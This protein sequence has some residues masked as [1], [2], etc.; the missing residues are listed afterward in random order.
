MAID[1]LSYRSGVRPQSHSRDVARPRQRRAGVSDDHEA[2][3]RLVAEKII[4]EGHG[5]RGATLH[6]AYSNR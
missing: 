3:T 4:E 6:A 2:T 1:S 5:M